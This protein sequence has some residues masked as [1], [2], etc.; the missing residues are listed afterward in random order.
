MQRLENYQGIVVVTTNAGQY[1]DTA[2]QR[3]MDVVVNFQPPGPAE[4]LAILDLHLP[5]NH[6]VGPSF[7]EQAAA[8]CALAGG[9]LRNA[10]LA[11]GL[12]ALDEDLPLGDGHLFAGLLGEYRKAG[13]AFPLDDPMKDPVWAEAE[14]GDRGEGPP[15]PLDGYL[16]ALGPPWSRSI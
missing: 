9:Q 15:D 8:R 14:A 10:V 11:A 12:L 1:I 2:F 16:R 13:A 6:R 4:R 3:R 7:L 5:A